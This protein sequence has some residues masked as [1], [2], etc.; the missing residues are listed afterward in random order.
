MNATSVES[1]KNPVNVLITKNQM[2]QLIDAGYEGMTP[3]VKLFA[4]P[5]TWL[6][7]GYEDGYFY[8]YGDLSQG[9]VEWGGLTN[10]EEL[11]TFKVGPFWLERD[12]WFK[13]TEGTNYLNMDS[14]AGI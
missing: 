11:P 7:T 5:V 8:G 2:Q 6:L 3:I 4:G 10:I 1:I 9:C 13:H 14:L 12:T